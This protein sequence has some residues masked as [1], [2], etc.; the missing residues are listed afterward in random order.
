[1]T[2]ESTNEDN[3]PP[4]NEPER[5]PQSYPEL[6]SPDTGPESRL[7][8]QGFLW[9]SSWSFRLALGAG[10]LAALAVLFSYQMR[11]CQAG[12]IEVA[13][14]TQESAQAVEAAGKAL[15][16][17][18]G[19]S[20]T[21]DNRGVIQAPRE[22]AQFIVLEHDVE[23][24]SRLRRTRSFGWF[25]AHL[26][27]KGRYRGLLGIDVEEVRG[28]F[29]P[30][31]L[32][33]TLDLPPT[34]LLALETVSMNHSDQDGWWVNSMGTGDAVR[35]AEL[36]RVA[37]REQLKRKDLRNTADRHL[38]QRLR[39]ALTAASVTLNLSEL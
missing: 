1:M 36:S 8:R 12:A 5:H 2:I 23:I 19:G 28:H 6:L 37:A 21:I 16:E 38:R 25:P 34:K 9:A 26:V 14:A 18:F 24:T 22:V 27:I 4:S 10:A 13:G 15:S 30:D 39:T 3:I 17:I 32:T 33:L 31:T 29:D 11:G 20:L 35:L 7:P